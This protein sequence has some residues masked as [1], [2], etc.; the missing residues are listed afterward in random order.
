[1]AALNFPS[2]PT[3]GQTFVAGSISY[4]YDGAKWVA[5]IAPGATGATGPIGGPTFTVVNSGASSY[6]INLSN[7]PTLR[8]M[9][10]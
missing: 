1:M 6:S 9:R 2:Q 7:N 3:Q 10:G 5:G 8:L 4:T